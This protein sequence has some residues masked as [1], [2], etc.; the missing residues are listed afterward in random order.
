LITASVGEGILILENVKIP[1]KSFCTPEEE[2]LI[3]TKPE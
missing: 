2:K 3:T 1:F